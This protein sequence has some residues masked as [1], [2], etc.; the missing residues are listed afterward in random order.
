MVWN[1]RLQA[2]EKSA[3]TL[4][5][6]ENHQF[7][8]SPPSKEPRKAAWFP[9]PPFYPLNNPMNLGRPWHIDWPT[10]RYMA[11]WRSQPGSPE[12]DTLVTTTYKLSIQISQQTCSLQSRQSSISKLHVRERGYSRSVL[13]GE[14]HTF[15]L[16]FLVFPVQWPWPTSCSKT[17][18][19]KPGE[20]LPIKTDNTEI[21]RPMI[22]HGINQLLPL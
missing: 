8:S 14:Y 1:P 11:V 6:S 18:A 13:F 4:S 17:P 3:I 20:S 21:N 2:R 19:W 15:Y 9:P 5:H 7:V 12:A 16:R 22:W 10:M